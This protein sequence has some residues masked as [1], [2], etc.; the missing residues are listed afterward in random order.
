MKIRHYRCKDCEGLDTATTE[1]RV[2]W[3]VGQQVWEP[4]DEM[5]DLR[6]CECDS[7]EIESYTETPT[8]LVAYVCQTCG[9]DDVRQDASARWEPL[10][11]TLE[12]TATYDTWIC[13]S[14]DGLETKVKEIP[15]KEASR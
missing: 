13:E 5:F 3:D 15:W 2:G 7:W 14:C 11:Q 8:D 12:L 9:S 6:C 4:L 10:T 1:V